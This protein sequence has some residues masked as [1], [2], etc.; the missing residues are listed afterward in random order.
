MNPGHPLLPATAVGSVQSNVMDT[1]PMGIHIFLRG[2]H[3]LRL[4]VFLAK[5]W[6]STNVRVFKTVDWTSGTAATSRA[7][8]ASTEEHDLTSVSEDVNY[9]SSP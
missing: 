9:V 5:P 7:A 2:A 8:S 3:V 1:H 4:G 6:S